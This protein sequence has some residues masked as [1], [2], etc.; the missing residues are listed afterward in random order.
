[1]RPGSA[2]RG[3]PAGNLRALELVLSREDS[4]AIDA[5]DHGGRLVSPCFA[6]ARD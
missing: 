2:R 5:L 4:A 1:M 3:N 6:P